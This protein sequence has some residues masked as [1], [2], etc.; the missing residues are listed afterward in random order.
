M[1][2]VARGLQ[3]RRWVDKVQG[4]FDSHSPPPYFV[5][6]PWR[7]GK[8]CFL[9]VGVLDKPFLI[10]STGRPNCP[11]KFAEPRCFQ[12]EAGKLEFLRQI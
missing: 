3:S 5:F 11:L 12:H 8:R 4:G 1:T 6:A 2:G 9:P 10:V 7:Y